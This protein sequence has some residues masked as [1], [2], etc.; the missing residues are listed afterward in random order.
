MKRIHDRPLTP[1]RRARLEFMKEKLEFH[2]TPR[3]QTKDDLELHRRMA[4]EWALGILEFA[5]DLWAQ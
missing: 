3:I 1:Y 2:L 4:E 5:E